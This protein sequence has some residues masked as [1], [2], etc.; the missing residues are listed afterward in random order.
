MAGTRQ[1]ARE[2][3]KKGGRPKGSKSRPSIFDYWDKGAIDEFFEF[4]RDNYKEDSRL[5][6]WVGDHILG[7]APQAITGP[8]GGPI[9]ISEIEVIVRK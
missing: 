3:G 6:V 8:D 1:I 9:Q 2:N 7:K 4:L 5:M